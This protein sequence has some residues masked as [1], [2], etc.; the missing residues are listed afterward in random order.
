MGVPF[1]GA[2][3][4]TTPKIGLV[5][6]EEKI[7]WRATRRATLVCLVTS[8]L[9][10]TQPLS[11][12]PPLWLIPMKGGDLMTPCCGEGLVVGALLLALNWSFGTPASA[13]MLVTPLKEPGTIWKALVK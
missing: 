8:K 7:C 10:S 1:M 9:T 6:L 11:G 13:K 3:T 12:A 4:L 2:M 5:R